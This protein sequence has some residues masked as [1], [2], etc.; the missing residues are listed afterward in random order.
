MSNEIE[1]YIKELL[2]LKSLGLVV[3]ED[4]EELDGLIEKLNHIDVDEENL[5]PNN[6]E[7][8][9]PIKFVNTSNN[10]DPIYAKD[11]DSGFDLRAN[12]T[13]T[14]FKNGQNI[15]VN[16]EYVMKPFERSLIPTGL[17]FELPYGYELQIR[18]RSGH[19]FKTG[20]MAI[21]GTVDRDYRGEVKV[22]LINLSD[23]DVT[24][25]HGERIAQGVVAPRVS[26]EIGKLV[27]LTSVD[28]LSETERGVSGFGSTGN[29]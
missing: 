10:P 26:T 2:H 15:E 6:Q 29:K 9:I 20:L 13:R 21:L 12:F 7:F 19:S 3:G 4:A 28:E 23:K 27:K 16:H 24:I 18:P 25:E 14:I 5:N 8:N 1:N 22:I 17:F 11:G